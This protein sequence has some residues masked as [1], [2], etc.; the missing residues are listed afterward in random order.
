LLLHC[1]DCQP[2]A[3]IIVLSPLDSKF[4][5]I[6]G[7]GSASPKIALQFLVGEISPFFENQKFSKNGGEG[8]I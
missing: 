5:T 7:G 6:S 3:R 1:V 2:L 4:A 8:E